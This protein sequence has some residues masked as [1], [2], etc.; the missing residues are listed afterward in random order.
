[1]G[2]TKLPEFKGKALIEIPSFVPQIGF[3]E[4]DFGKAFLEEYQGKARTDYNG[5]SALN[6]LNYRDGVVKGSNPFAVVLANQIL[7]QEGLRTASQADLEKALRLGCVIPLR[8]IYEDT[9]LV[10]RSEEDQDYSRN[11]PL[12]KDLGKQVKARGIKFDSKNPVVIPLAGLEL[13]RAENQYG[14]AFKLIDGAEIYNARVLRSGGNFTSED[15][16]EKT[17][18]PKQLGTGN[19]TLF[20]RGSGLSS[21]YLYIDLN[22]VSNGRDLDDSVD[23][24]RVVVV[25]AEGTSPEKSSSDI[26]DKINSDYQSRLTELETRKKRALEAVSNIMSGK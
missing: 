5:N 12:A 19:R 24:G 22:L 18:L 13:Q 4:G 10:L 14:L 7:R 25:S 6:V 9:G 16:D 3:L 20:T 21:L 2:K 8:G 23:Y 1:M 15:I 26:I 11:T 17:G